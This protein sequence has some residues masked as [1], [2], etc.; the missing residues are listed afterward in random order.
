MCPYSNILR[1]T[2]EFHISDQSITLDNYESWLTYLNSS[3]PA[4]VESLELR[5]CDLQR[6]LDQVSVVPRHYHCHWK[7]YI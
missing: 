5:H 3:D 2:N 6:F 4:R 7:L 1:L